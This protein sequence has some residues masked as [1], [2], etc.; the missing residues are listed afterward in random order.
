VEGVS[1]A[2]VKP[3]INLIK[4]ETISNPKSYPKESLGTLDDFVFFADDATKAV[5][6]LKN[7]I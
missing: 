4:D 3:V 6:I 2:A 7:K 5:S 1:P